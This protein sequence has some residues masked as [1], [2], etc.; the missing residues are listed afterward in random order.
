MIFTTMRLD[1]SAKGVIVDKEERNPSPGSESPVV[2][3]EGDEEKPA[4][5]PKKWWAK[6]QKDM[7]ENVIP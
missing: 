3:D 5:D 1:T 7:Q 2:K 4:K 6:R